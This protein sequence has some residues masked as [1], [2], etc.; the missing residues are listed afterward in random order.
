M[1]PTEPNKY[2]IYLDYRGYMIDRRSY[3]V[4]PAPLLGT[5]FATGRMAYSNLDFWQI[6]AM[7][8]FTKGINQQFLVDPSQSYSSE[9]LDLSMEGELKLERDL[10][11]QAFPSGVGFVT[12]RYRSQDALYLGTSFGKVLKSTDGLTLPEVAHTGNGKIYSF[13]EMENDDG[14][15][16]LYAVKGPN[17][18]W[19][20]KSGGSWH[21]CTGTGSVPEIV[22]L[23]YTMI[24]SDYAYG[25]F[26]D[27]IRQSIN[28]EDWIPEP[29][30]PLWELPASEGI[31]LNAMPIPRGY[32]IGAR[33][34]LWLFMGGGSAVNIWLFP[35]Y[36]S[37]LNFRGMGKFGPYGI[38]SVEGM[39]LFYTDGSGIFPTNLNWTGKALAITSAKCVLNSGW[40]MLALVS[41]GTDWYLARCS[42]KNIK[43]PKYWWI[44]KKLS[45]IP[46]YLSAYNNEKVFIHYMDGSCKK[47]NKISGAFQTTGVLK[48]SWIDENMVLLRK[49]YNSLSLLLSNF[50]TSTTAKLSYLLKDGGIELSE[51]WDGDSSTNKTFNL[52]N[53]TLSTRIQIGVTLTTSDTTVSPIVTD[54]CWKFILERPIGEE[55]RRRVWHFVVLG[56]DEL[57][58]LEGDKEELGLEIPRTR[59]EILDNLWETRNKLEVLNYVGLDNVTSL[60]FTLRYTGSGSS[61]RMRIDR[62]NYKITTWVDTKLDQEISYKDLTISALV[63]ALDGLGNY[64]CEKN[65]SVPQNQSAHSLF[66]MDEI[67]LKGR[68]DVFWGTDVHTVIFNP[69]SPTQIKLSIDGRG[70]DRVNISLRE[71]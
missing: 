64:S 70:S 5:K 29:P 2:H 58:K 17:R 13:Y 6:G 33:R 28:G 37:D 53:P 45:K 31:A 10:E 25:V 38:F 1:I 65:K 62:T 34:G 71:A 32:L 26:N 46:A 27:G 40:D 63:A 59:Q 3:R 11:A 55:S 48:T 47:Y 4:T 23:Y 49:L 50:P 60:A 51:T 7:T 42:M 22:N 35:D 41:D 43:L 67:E 24:E 66:P 21:E 18:S 12:A 36:A 39:G 44:I 15:V 30:D 16:Y 20:K 57:E 9:G 52:G 8:D 68:A 56:E 61:C 54:L 69:Q 14:D 19:R